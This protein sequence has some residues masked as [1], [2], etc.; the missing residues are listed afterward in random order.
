MAVWVE[1]LQN[2]TCIHAARLNWMRD[3]ITAG[4]AFPVTDCKAQRF[5][6]Q[7]TLVAGP[8]GILVVWQDR[9]SGTNRIYGSVSKDAQHFSPPIQI[10]ETI[11]KSATYGSGSSAINPVVTQSAGRFWVLWLDKRA[12]RSGYKIYSAQSADGLTWSSNAPV[13]DSFGDETP[14]WSVSVTQSSAGEAFAV[15]SDAR[16]GNGQDVYYAYFRDGAW[17][18][19]NLIEHAAAS[20]DQDSP[21]LG[22]DAAGRI[23]LIW[24]HQPDEGTSCIKYAVGSRVADD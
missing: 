23:H 22:S 15:W 17:G 24:R 21:A 18:D 20:R 6:A 10:N 13:Q 8:K 7:P 1:T 9:S 2:G 4:R 19:N 5:Q 11:Q 14:Q 3:S 16:E 12:E